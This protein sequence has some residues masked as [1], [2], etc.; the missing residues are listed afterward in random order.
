MRDATAHLIVS[1]VHCNLQVG[2][3][4]D[5]FGIQESCIKYTHTHPGRQDKAIHSEAA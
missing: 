5:M 4:F 1:P 3:T 2:N